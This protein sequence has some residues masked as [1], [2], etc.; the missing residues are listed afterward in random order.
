M[1]APEGCTFSRFWQCYIFKQKAF[2]LVV[3]TMENYPI[4]ISVDEKV[5]HFEVGEYA[6]HDDRRCKYRVFE[7]GLFVASFEPDDD[8]FLQI[9]QNIG[10]LDQLLLHRLAEQ[11]EAHHPHGINDKLEN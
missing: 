9:C 8:E 7:N 5:H 6:H 2:E 11:I 4:T 3:L 1:T 10:N